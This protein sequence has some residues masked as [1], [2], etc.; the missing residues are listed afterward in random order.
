MHISLLVLFSA[1]WLANSTV[2]FPG[3]Q[4]EGVLG[5]QGIGVSVPMAAAVA[6][7]TTGLASD[8]HIPKGVMLT[9]GLLSIILACGLL[10]FITRFT[11]KTTSDAG[12]KP[13]LHLIIAPLHTYS[14]IINL[15]L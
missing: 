13:M 7:A 5:M 9:N 15:F 11:G 2:G 6:D 14:A 12:A 1:G 4:G 3:I 8:R 10:L